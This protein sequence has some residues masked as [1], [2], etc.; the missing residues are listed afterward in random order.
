MVYVLITEDGVD[1]IVETKEIAQREKHDLV[2]L[3]C[4]VKIKEFASWELAQAFADK[5]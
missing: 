1:Q 3:G 2:K 5:F 4:S